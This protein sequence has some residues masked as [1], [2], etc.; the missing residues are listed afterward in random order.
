MLVAIE[1]NGQIIEVH[2]SAVADHILLGWKRHEE[3]PAS[4]EDISAMKASFKELT[5]RLDEQGARIR[6]LE[7]DLDLVTDEDPEEAAALARIS[8]LEAK[9]ADGTITRGEKGVLTKLKNAT[10]AE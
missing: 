2:P 6:Q 1:K 8:E 10:K 5:A 9:L 3:A 7:G 4:Q